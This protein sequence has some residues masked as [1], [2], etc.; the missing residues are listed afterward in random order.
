MPVF[1]PESAGAHT[2]TR[3]VLAAAPF[4]DVREMGSSKIARFLNLSSLFVPNINPTSRPELAILRKGD[5]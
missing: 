5:L 4:S 2:S 3:A 1:S